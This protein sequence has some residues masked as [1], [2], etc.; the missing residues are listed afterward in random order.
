MALKATHED[1]GGHAA[2]V[3]LTQGSRSDQENALLEQER[4]SRRTVRELVGESQGRAA[5]SCREEV[6]QSGGR[7]ELSGGG[8]CCVAICLGLGD[9][10]IVAVGARP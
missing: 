9:L 5:A 4:Q 3:N 2:C 1:A 6:Q 7:H 8:S 10:R